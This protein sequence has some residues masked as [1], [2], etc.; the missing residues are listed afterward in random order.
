MLDSDTLCFDMYG[1]LCDT[2]SVSETL[3]A[4]LD[5]PAG[6]VADVDALW[7]Q[8]QLRYAQQVALMDDYVTFR[9]VTERALAYALDYYNL[10]PDRSARERILASYDHLEPYPD[11][12]DALGRLGDDRTLA[13]LSNGN[14][15]MLETLAE[16]A[17]LAPHLDELV[18]ADE[19]AT[20]KP[21]PAV[22]R[23][24]ADR[25]D[26]DLGDCVLVSS[27]AWDVA[28]AASAGMATAW[29]NRAREPA[30]TVGGDADIAVESLSHLAD[31]LS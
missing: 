5:L 6:F 26:R 12:V 24:A 3:S 4:E 22:Y 17:G 8:T 21:D 14:P 29:V 20:F 11:A 31:S 9:T 7:R 13:V 27:N 1:T 2:T 16:N 15:E 18:S 10:D 30:E 25:L 28:G 19:V 23:N